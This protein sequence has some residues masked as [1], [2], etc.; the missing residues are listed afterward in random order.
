MATNNTTFVSGSI[1]TATQVNNLA[2]GHIAT[3]TKTTDQTFTALTDMAGLSITF[4]PVVNRIYEMSFTG[5]L[6]SSGGTDCAVYLTDG[7]TNYYESLGS[8][9]ASAPFQSRA[10]TVTVS[11]L[12]AVSKTFKIQAAAAG[13]AALYGT[14]ARAS[15][16]AR[17][18]ITD[19][20]AA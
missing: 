3:A 9:L 10:F 18:V 2:W 15:I 4:T 5:N 1:L 19:I 8:I 7:T 17:L 6:Q 14:G 16:A 20:G 12:T 13:T 11:G